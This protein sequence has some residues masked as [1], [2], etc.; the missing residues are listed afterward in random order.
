MSNWKAVQENWGP[1][2][3]GFAI[4][5]ALVSAYATI[6]IQSIV[7]E[8]GENLTPVQQEFKIDLALAK[9]DA[10][11]NK[12]GIEDLKKGQTK[13]EKKLDDLITLMLKRQ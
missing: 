11:H 2:A 13:I 9:N 4:V 3:V 10:A 1:I 12:E 6:Y 7:K 8:A 5:V